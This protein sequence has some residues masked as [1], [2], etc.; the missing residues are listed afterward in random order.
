MRVRRKNERDVEEEAVAY[1]N[2]Y[3]CHAAWRIKEGKSV[4]E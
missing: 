2:G 4:S 3:I 1:V